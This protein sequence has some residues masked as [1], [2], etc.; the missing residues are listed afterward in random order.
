M[1]GTGSRLDNLSAAQGTIPSWNT[2]AP[3]ATLQDG[4]TGYA[5][6][7]FVEIV[8]DDDPTVKPTFTGSYTGILDNFAVT[9]YLSCPAYQT[10][11][12]P[13]PLSFMLTVDGETVMDRTAIDAQV[14]VPIT[15][16]TDQYG[17]LKFAFTNMYKALEALGMDNAADTQHTISF[18]LINNYWADG[19][20]VILYDAT[21]TPTGNIFNIETNKLSPFTK[22]DTTT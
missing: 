8:A 16:V 5:A 15:A 6:V 12:T 17:H 18:H 20:A 9:M 21:E 14:D 19:N 13:F 1:H 2:T 10:T 4:G 3:T 22:I 11:G 7:R